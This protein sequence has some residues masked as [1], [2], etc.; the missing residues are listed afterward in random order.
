MAIRRSAKEEEEET[1]VLETSRQQTSSL[2]WLGITHLIL[3]GVLNS[4]EL[5]YANVSGN[6]KRQLACAVWG[7]DGIFHQLALALA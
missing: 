1:T 6:K 3:Q 2:A 5:I 7:F 4:S